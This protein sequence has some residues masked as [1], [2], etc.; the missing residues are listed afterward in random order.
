MTKDE[1]LLLYRKE[2]E[3]EETVFGDYKNIK[4]LSLPSFI[5]FLRKYLNKVDNA[6]SGKWQS[7]LPHWL[8]S[9]R[10]F[11]DEGTAPV[12]V[13]EELIKLM[14]LAGVVEM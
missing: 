12:E 5:V 2:R 6:Y 4:S 13:Y 1:V 3:Y 14:A 8:L 7:E 10:E 11:E 9:C